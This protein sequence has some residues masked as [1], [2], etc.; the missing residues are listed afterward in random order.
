MKGRGAAY[1]PP[2]GGSTPPP[3]AVARSPNWRQRSTPSISR[4]GGVLGEHRNN[5]RD[6]PGPFVGNKTL[7]TVQ[8]KMIQ[9]YSPFSGSSMIPGI[10]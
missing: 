1:D 8:I 7:A 4:S 5:G 2:S 9:L 10:S 6:D 3:A